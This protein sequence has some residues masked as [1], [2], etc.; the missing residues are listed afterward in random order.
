MTAPFD[1]VALLT[2]LDHHRVRFI[3]IGGFAASVLGS[4][5]LT[6]DLDI[7]YDRADQATRRALVAALRT[8]DAKPREWPQGVPFLLDERTIQLGDSFTFETTFGNRDCMATPSG[9]TGYPDLLRHA[10]EIDLGEGLRVLF[11]SLGDLMRMKQAAARPKDLIELEVLAALAE[12]R[13]KIPDP[14]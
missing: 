11:T 10:R 6:T 9:T 4:P 7:C 2:T 14:D 13:E 12:E 5:T 1:P 3:V 8:M